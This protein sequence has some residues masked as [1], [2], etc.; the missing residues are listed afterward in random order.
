MRVGLSRPLLP[1]ACSFWSGESCE[2]LCPWYLASM[3]FEV[4]RELIGNVD[5]LEPIIEQAQPGIGVDVGRPHSAMIRIAMGVGADQRHVQLQD[6]PGVLAPVTPN[7][8]I[9]FC[10]L[11]QVDALKLLGPA[12]GCCQIE[13]APIAIGNARLTVEE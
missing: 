4:D 6:V 7:A 12:I 1:V 2:G 5:A 11:L 13:H 9:W 10:S 8:D 3:G